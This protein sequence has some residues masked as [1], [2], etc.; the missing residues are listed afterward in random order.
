MMMLQNGCLPTSK[1]PS[2]SHV[3]SNINMASEIWCWV[4]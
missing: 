1:A 3:S 4:E 2:L